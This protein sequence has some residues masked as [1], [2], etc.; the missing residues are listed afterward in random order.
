MIKFYFKF[1][2]NIQKS[3]NK[4]YSNLSYILVLQTSTYKKDEREDY[5]LVY[6]TDREN[7]K[8]IFVELVM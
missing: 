6:Q 2:N 5:P 4:Q 1:F 7:R 3:T 8:L